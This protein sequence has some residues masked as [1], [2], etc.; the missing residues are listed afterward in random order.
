MNYFFNLFTSAS[1]LLN[2][3]NVSDVKKLTASQDASPGVSIMFSRNLIDI[4]DDDKLSVEGSIRETLARGEAAKHLI[5]RPSVA[6]AGV[7]YGQYRQSGYSHEQ[8]QQEIIRIADAWAVGS[9]ASSLEPQLGDQEILALVARVDRVPLSD[10]GGLLD[11][12][13]QYGSRRQ[14]RQSVEKSLY[15]T[16]EWLVRW[17]GGENPWPRPA[18]PTGSGPI[19]GR[20]RIDSGTTFVDDTGPVL[21]TYAHAG[22]LFS[23]YV[24]N[25]E[26][27]LAE[28]DKITRAGYHGVRVWGVLGCGSRSPQGCPPGEYWKGREVGPDLTPGYWDLLKQ[29]STEVTNRKLRLVFSQGDIGQLRDRRDYM[30]RVAQL[31]NENPF[32]DW[33]DCGNEAWQ[34]GEPDPQRLATCV[35]Y[36]ASAGGQALKTLTDAPIYLSDLSPA[37]EFNRY[38]IAPADAFDIHSYRGGHSWDKRRHIWGY[39]YCGE[40]CPTKKVGIGSEPPGSGKKVSAIDNIHELDDEAVALLAL[41]SHIGRQAFVWFSGEGVI[42]DEGLQVEAGFLSVPRAVA[43]LPRDVY[44]YQTTHHSGE[45][46]ANIRVL[47]PLGEVR[48]DGRMASDG[49]FVYTIDG[50]P[51]SYSLEVKRKFEGKLCHPGTG[52]CEDISRERGQR[53][54]IGFLRG[55]LFMGRAF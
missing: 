35:G 34:T 25:Q 29:F 39:T 16:G 46:F 18:P 13:V 19:V 6:H 26:R 38:S 30:T 40:G 12:G 55:R 49:R 23:I 17:Y 48:I 11:L 2:G 8:A 14:S 31:D 33:I 42:I 54:E 44:T 21:P 28:L 47:A 53:L 41:A 50:P 7:I 45:S 15:E 9:G 4:P 52:E 27:A 37:E 32:I 10:W 24:R 3:N 51:G 1:L 5:L 22:D 43:L 20:L 36:Y